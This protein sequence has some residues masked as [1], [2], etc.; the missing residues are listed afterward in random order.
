MG[1]ETEVTSARA[2]PAH[3][4]PPCRTDRPPSRSNT[5]DMTSSK[6]LY[7]AAC[8]VALLLLSGGTVQADEWKSTASAHSSGYAVAGP[9]GTKSNSVTKTVS[10][11]ADIK[12]KATGSAT[13][14]STYPVYEYYYDPWWKEEYKEYVRDDTS[15]SVSTAES[16]S[17]IDEAGK[18]DNDAKSTM[19]AT[20]EGDMV[21]K[22]TGS[23][24]AKA[25]AKIYKKKDDH[26]DDPKIWKKRKPTKK[27]KRPVVRRW[28]HDRRSLLTDEDEWKSTT[29]AH[30]SG[31]AF[32]GPGGTKSNSVTKTVSK[33]ANIRNKA[34]GSATAM[35]TYPVYEY[36]YYDP[37]WKH[38]EEEDEDHEEEYDHEEYPVYKEYVRDDTSRSV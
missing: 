12:N 20:V 31:Y 16:K 23:A 30:S 4:E 8:S 11:G 2:H 19:K 3:T 33:G 38:E 14:M 26:A 9:G 36:Y 18:I 10:K 1:T 17:N 6:S 7:V 32:A 34:T 13:A 5:D 29:S 25:Y 37:R 27:W 22:A 28:K 24:D 35:S 15:R 21:A